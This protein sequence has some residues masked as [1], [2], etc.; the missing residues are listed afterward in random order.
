MMFLERASGRQTL[1]TIFASEKN[2]C[3]GDIQS[4]ILVLALLANTAIILMRVYI[5]NP[6]FFTNVEYLKPSP[7]FP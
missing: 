1:F 3:Q 4:A 2:R 7:P 6:D 5:H